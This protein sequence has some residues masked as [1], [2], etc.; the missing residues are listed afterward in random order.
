MV[1]EASF[2]DTLSAFLRR[3][4]VL[5]HFT[6]AVSSLCDVGERTLLVNQAEKYHGS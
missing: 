6:S 4:G 1:M 5:F 2:S 3:S